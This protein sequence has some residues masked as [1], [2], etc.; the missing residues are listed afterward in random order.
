VS[1]PP[2]LLWEYNNHAVQLLEPVIRHATGMYGDDYAQQHLWGPIGMDAEWM[3]DDVGHPA[4]Y[5]NVLASC[6]DHARFGYLFLKRGCW[7]GL[8][9]ISEAWVDIATSPSQNM[10]RGYGYWWWLS[11]ETPTLDSTDFSELP[12]GSLHPFAPDDAFCAV[13]LGSQFIEVI[14]SLDMVV[15]RMG[16]A[17]HDDW[18]AWLQPFQL[19]QDLLEDGKQILHNGVLERVLDAVVH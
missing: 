16:T 11:G 7:D 1:N 18:T 4:L 8:Q 13:G 12:G 2:G 14:P 15:V 3:K 9:V 10:S 5:M 6:R 17:P 19:I